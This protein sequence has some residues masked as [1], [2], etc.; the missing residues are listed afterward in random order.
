MVDA[1]AA[2]DLSTVSALTGGA[3]SPPPG[4]TGT[5]RGRELRVERRPRPA[6]PSTSRCQADFW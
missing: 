6:G 4:T 3:A 5:S 2:Y 1:T